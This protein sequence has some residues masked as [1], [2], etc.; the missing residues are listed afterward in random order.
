VTK[1]VYNV[2]G[3]ISRELVGKNPENQRELDAFMVEKLDG[4]K[5]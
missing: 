5:N 3:I 2:N 4:T 1:A